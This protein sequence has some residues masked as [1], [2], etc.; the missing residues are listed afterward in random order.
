MHHFSLTYTLEIGTG[1]IIPFQKN[2]PNLMS[3]GA[4][5]HLDNPEMV[6]I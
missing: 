2:A 3:Y 5:N 1:D 6:Q 4:K